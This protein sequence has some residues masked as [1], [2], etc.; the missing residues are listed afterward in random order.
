MITIYY[1]DASVIAKLFLEEPGSEEA[2]KIFNNASVRKTTSLCF[3]ESLAVL[4]CKLFKKKKINEYLNA[5]LDL[6]SIKNDSNLEIEE[7]SIFNREMFDKA[8][9]II[10]ENKKVDLADIFQILSIEESI[11]THHGIPCI[12]VTADGPLHELA[13]K[14]GVKSI[15]IQDKP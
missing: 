1:F 2:R 4:K 9:S 6:I 13:I 10:E 14:R 8:Q 12:L 15:L 7:Q 5:T 3:S 11:Y